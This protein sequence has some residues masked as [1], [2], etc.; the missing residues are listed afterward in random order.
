MGR[1]PPQRMSEPAGGAAPARGGYGLGIFATMVFRMSTVAA[2]KT[3]IVTRRPGPDL[4]YFSLMAPMQN[5]LV[6][7]ERPRRARGA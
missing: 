6:V 4:G 3:S 5:A 1:E 7:P 2:M